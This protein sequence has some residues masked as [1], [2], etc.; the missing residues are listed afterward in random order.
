MQMEAVWDLAV[1]R[2]QGLPKHR[3]VQIKIPVWQE[4]GQWI[5]MKTVLR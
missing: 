4:Q 3:R 2:K 5:R 1:R